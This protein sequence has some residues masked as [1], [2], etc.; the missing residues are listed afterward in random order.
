MRPALAP[1]LIITILGCHK[2]PATIADASLSDAVEPVEQTP[3]RQVLE[4]AAESLDPTPR[5]RALYWLIR[6]GELDTWAPR[7]IYDPS[8]WVQRVAVDALVLRGPAAHEHLATLAARADAEPLVRVDAALALPDGYDVPA[9]AEAW[10]SADAPW[11]RAPLALAAHHLGD[12]DALDAVASSVA[13]GE[14]HLDLRFVD[15]LAIHGG[16][17]LEPALAT[18]QDRVEQE[19][20]I[21]IAASRLK[22][23]DPRGEGDLRKAVTGDVPQR[24]EALDALASIR[25]DAAEGLIRRARTGSADLV[26]WYADLLLAARY[27]VDPTQLVSAREQADPEV[28]RLAVHA[29]SI[30]LTDGP[31]HR[32]V[33]RA[34]R[35]VLVT[36]LSD[37]DATV[38]QR[39]A[40]AVGELAL[41]PAAS[42]LPPLLADEVGAV[43]LEAAGALQL[44]ESEA[45]RP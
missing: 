10:R 5:S 42:S 15:A 17:R 40:R 28:R 41:A 45:P 24:L 14:L 34:A 35:E 20:Q 3:P 27:G 44:I 37:P 6:T 12:A 39:A 7:A 16:P 18:A 25:D 4:A 11:D 30:A 21:A 2:P 29:A 32:K 43:R 31:A 13:T 26:R 33:A 19:L 22:V 8:P 23:G 9:L 38:R 36:S 1:L